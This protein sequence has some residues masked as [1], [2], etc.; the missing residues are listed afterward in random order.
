MTALTTDRATPARDGERYSHPVAATAKIY[1]GSLVVLNATGYAAP[2]STATG[3]IAAGRAE[4]QVDNSAGADGALSVEVS[5]GVFRFV[6][7]GDITR[8]HIGDSAYITDDQTVT[9]VT[10][11]R[12][13]AG[14]ITDVDASGVWVKI[15]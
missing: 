14:T 3:L 7:E 13:V 4:A 12:S 11:G 9:A 10:T 2:G 1:A 5:T 15:G 8:A 6:N